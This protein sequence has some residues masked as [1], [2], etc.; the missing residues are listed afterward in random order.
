[1][2]AA[3]AQRQAAIAEAAAGRATAAASRA[4]TLSRRSAAAAR[5]ASAAADSAADHAEKAADAAEEAAR[6]AGKAVDYANRSTAAAN[7]AVEA[8]NKAYDAVTEAREVE[9]EAREA[10]IARL[11]EETE[12]AIE[13]AK[14]QRREETDRLERANRERTQESRL[15]EELVALITAMEAA[16]ADGRTGEAVDK[17]RQAAVLLLDRSGTWTRE[18]A[19]FALAGSD[20]DVLRWIEADRVIALQQDNAENTAAT[21]AIS[22][23]NVAEA[24]AAA[25]QTE[26]PAAI[27]TFLEKGAVEAARDDNE[28]EVTTLLADDST[29]TAVRRAAEAALTDGS[30]EALHTFLHVKRAAAVHEDDKVAATT[31]LVSGGP[32]VQAAAKVALEG[33]T[34]MLRQFIGTTQHEFA[35]IDHDHATHI[36]AIRAAIARAAKTAQDALEDAARASEAAAVARQAA[37][38]ATEWAGKAEGWAADAKASA[39]EARQNAEDAENSAAAAAR[40]AQTAANAA[41]AARRASSVARDAA[42]R[43]VRSAETAASYALDAQRSAT[44]ARQA[45]LA[46]GKSFAEAAAAATEARI[47]V[48]QA[49]IR[50]AIQD[51]LDN[52]KVPIDGETGLPDG[53]ESCLTPFGDPIEHRNNTNPWELGWSWLTGSGPT[54]QCFGPDDEF[55]R[56]Y[57]EH[58]HTQGVLAYFL[59]EWQ[60]TGKYEL[61]HTYMNDYMLSGFD[62]AGKYMT[63]YGTLTTGGLTGNLAYTFLGSH[64]V[65]M[66]PIRE[67]ADGSVTWRYTAYN[68]SDIESATHPPVI[69][70]TDWWSDTVGAFVD[71]V[72]GDEGPLSPKT[73]V[74][75]FDVT[76]GP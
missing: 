4:S 2:Q 11:N 27:R 66:T 37:A 63:D 36:S 51:A 68:E 40:S 72:V 26:D 59:N 8:A 67:N 75:E 17:G 48:I 41:A 50:Q 15:S 44:V 53:A 30:A 60:R 32:Y 58:S 3:E 34:H 61:G 16:F 24:A 12:E 25:L 69:G 35:R 74:I 1:S 65:R 31:L 21:A 19:E 54:S 9:K 45:K 55:T 52:S 73:Q 5:S 57:R 43:A 38:E 22:T 18:A 6:N 70:Y 71:K 46:A 23:Q 47:L 28:V 7:A 29:G 56:L 62:G 20:E 10:E 76:L 49:A 13:V 39:E 33:D 42:N 14:Q 64:Q